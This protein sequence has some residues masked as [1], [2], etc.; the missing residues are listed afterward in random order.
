MDNKKRKILLTLSFIFAFLIAISRVYLGVHYFSDVIG[1]S[2]IGIVCLL[3]CMNIIN[4][5]LKG[6]I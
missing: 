4:K 6:V 3:M 5:N 1:G 2:I